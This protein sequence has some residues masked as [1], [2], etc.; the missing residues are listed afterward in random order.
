[1][2]LLQLPFDIAL[3]RLKLFR[4]PRC[5]TAE[6]VNNSPNGLYSNQK[7]SIKSLN[8]SL[9]AFPDSVRQARLIQNLIRCYNYSHFISHAQQQESPLGR[10]DRALPDEFI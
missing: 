7:L 9:E 2:Q 5:Q 10:F 6:N 3:V 8:L 4:L 1:L